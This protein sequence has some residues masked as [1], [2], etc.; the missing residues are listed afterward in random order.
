MSTFV[1][2]LGDTWET[3]EYATAQTDTVIVAA[4][5]AGK[6]VQLLEWKWTSDTQLKITFEEGANL[7]DAQYCDARGGQVVPWS[8]AIQ[9]GENI[10]L[11]VTTSADGN[12]MIGV[13][14]RTVDV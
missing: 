13:L 9:L 1:S 3:A 6:A 2:L 4:P 11:T 12:V 10:A 7:V 5:G 14:Y 8:K